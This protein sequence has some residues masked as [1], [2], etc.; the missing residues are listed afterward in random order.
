MI[1]NMHIP[2]GYHHVWSEDF[3]SD[4]VDILSWNIEACPSGKD[5]NELQEYVQSDENVFIKDNMLHIRPVQ[6]F[7]ENGN[8]TYTSGLLTTKGKHEYTYGYFEFRA[9]IPFG[10][11]LIPY[12]KL[13]CDDKKYGVWPIGG[14]VDVM[15]IPCHIPGKHYATVHY[16][17]NATHE[18]SA[19]HFPAGTDAACDFHVYSVEWIPGFIKFAVDGINFF[20]VNVDAP[21]DH[22]F[23]IQLGLAIGGSL[24][25]AP[26]EFTR[27]EEDNS[28][29]VDY[30]RV[31][32]QETYGQQVTSRPRKIITVCGGW[33]DAENFNS[34][35][36]NL[37]KPYLTKDY[38]ISAFSF[39]TPDL[40]EEFKDFEELR[41]A[42]FVCKQDSAIVI[43]FAE[44]I[45]NKA[46]VQKII[47]DSNAKG[48][49]VL[50][51]EHEYKDVVNVKVNYEKG[52]EEVCRHMIEEHGYKNVDMFAG[53]RGNEFSEKRIEVFK[54]VLAENGISFDERKV[55]YG[56]FWE[57]RA[58][59]VLGDSLDSGYQ[60]PEA[61]I[62]AND[63]MAIGVCQELARRGY[64]IPDDV[65]IS[66]F[67]GI[68]TS[69]RYNPA[70]TSAAA[71]YSGFV[72]K[73][74]EIIDN[75][76]DL[77][78]RKN[79][80]A[81]PLTIDYEIIINSSCG[82][83]DLTHTKSQVFLNQP[84]ND[85]VDCFRHILEMGKFVS[86]T[87]KSDNLIDA[88][89]KLKDYVWIWKKQFYFVALQ[90]GDMKLRAL[91][92]GRNGD[93]TYDQRY[94]HLDTWLPQMDKHIAEDSG[95]N[96][97]LFKQI[98]VQTGDFAFACCGFDSITFRDQQRFEEFC[99]FVSTVFNS[100][101]NNQKYIRANKEI[102][103]IS[104]MDYLTGLYNRRGFFRELEARIARQRNGSS[105]LGIALFS[106]DMDGLKN[107]ND[108]YGHIEGD[109]ALSAFANILLRYTAGSGICARYGG[110]EFAFAYIMDG[111]EPVDIDLV[112]S[113]IDALIENDYNIS[114][115]P[116]PIGASIGYSETIIDSNFN[117][118]ELIRTADES[119]YTEK[120]R[121]KGFTR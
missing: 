118:E 68:P 121:R 27:F 19:Y 104:E 73:V 31:Y 103:R 89:S 18:Q 58:A 71:D 12:I 113:S 117:L 93:Y 57:T 38:V 75:W 100:V 82:C 112:R 49:P 55:H 20:E 120:Q 11:G 26:D 69:Q 23:Y 116:Y 80:M 2:N 114:R 88:M 84:V 4:S 6:K 36:S 51:L 16:G 60:L 17:V 42:D 25:G 98:K 21:F 105:T 81:E 40:K 83:P 52:F 94:M 22:P 79:V 43:L 53:Q 33:Q 102:E 35:V 63:S 7:D 56:N 108:N 34:F 95:E 66:G 72:N 87:I 37:Q 44:M 9:K 119:M 14:Q 107:I 115:K 92:T 77:E 32:Q 1:S 61:I 24:S 46:V 3:N 54:K 74:L 78:Y 50:V 110:D 64:R 76:G 41:F 47:S 48:I 30:I 59:N 70:I 90:G 39:G 45:R 99:L 8:I 111:A 109:S 62:C 86:N 85:S 91:F 65:K 13:C 96:I 67:D 28:F 101:Y 97:F 29:V 106:V 5:N 15:Q 10:H